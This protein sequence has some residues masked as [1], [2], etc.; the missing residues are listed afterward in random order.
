MNRELVEEIASNWH[1]KS[2][3]LAIYFVNI[4]QEKGDETTMLYGM[5]VNDEII[6]LGKEKKNKTIVV[7]GNKEIVGKITL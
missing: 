5:L 2:K 3:G 6:E 4:D 1:H 7:Y